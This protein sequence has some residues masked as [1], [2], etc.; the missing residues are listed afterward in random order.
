MSSKFGFGYFEFLDSQMGTSTPAPIARENSELI[1]LLR[2]Q[3]NDLTVPATEY[4][5][6]AFTEWLTTW[7]NTLTAP[8]VDDRIRL[9]S[10]SLVT[11]LW[12]V[13]LSPYA[14]YVVA[15]LDIV[16]ETVEGSPWLADGNALPDER[17]H[18]GIA[19]AFEFTFSGQYLRALSVSPYFLSGFMV[20][21]A[22][23]DC[24]AD[25]A[26][27]EEVLSQWLERFMLEEV[28]RFDQISDY[29]V[30]GITPLDETG[31]YLVEFSV[32]PVGMDASR[33]AKDYPGMLNPY[34][35]W[36]TRMKANLMVT[37]FNEGIQIAIYNP[38]A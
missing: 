3:I 11:I 20:E 28:H 27:V 29:E 5:Y 34:T 6:E 15:L 37:C 21:N 36:L 35:Y 18:Y 10:A 7:V 4:G 24:P 25:E 22:T 17:G 14:P 16:P 33:W 13:Q 32:M 23:A 19:L 30:T 26:F 12:D 9:E 1:P 8:G 31:T 38:E 2:S